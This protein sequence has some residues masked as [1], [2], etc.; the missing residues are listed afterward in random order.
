M[1][2]QPVENLSPDKR[3]TKLTIICD[4]IAHLIYGTAILKKFD[5]Q[6]VFTGKQNLLNKCSFLKGKNESEL[7]NLPIRESI[8]FFNFLG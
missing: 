5:G 2:N 8:N 1:I 4:S 6:I 7:I 3:N